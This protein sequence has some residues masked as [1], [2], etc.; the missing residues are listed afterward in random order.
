ML[1]AKDILILTQR[2]RQAAPSSAIRKELQV[3]K[4]TQEMSVTQHTSISV[5]NN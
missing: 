2:K 1:E 5:Q 4:Q 3:S